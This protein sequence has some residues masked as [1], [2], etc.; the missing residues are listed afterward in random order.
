MIDTHQG[1]VPLCGWI[2]GRV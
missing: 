1:C 2:W